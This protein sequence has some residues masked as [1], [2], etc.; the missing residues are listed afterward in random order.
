MEAEPHTNFLSGFLGGFLLR[1][2]AA[3]CAAAGWQRLPTAMSQFSPQTQLPQSTLKKYEM[4]T[5]CKR[6]SR[7]AALKSD[8]AIWLVVKNKNVSTQNQNLSQG[9][10]FAAIYCNN[11]NI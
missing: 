1:L 9:A 4:V 6:P 8:V 10:R 11:V 5:G 2:C 7:R 3:S